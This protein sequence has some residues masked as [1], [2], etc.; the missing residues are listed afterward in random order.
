MPLKPAVREDRQYRPL[1]VVAVGAAVLFAVVALWVVRAPG[2]LLPGDAGLHHWS[3]GHRPDVAAALARAITDTATGVVPYALVVLAGLF[4]GRTRLRRVTAAVGLA[5]CLAVGQALRFGAM[6]LIARPRP[7]A[8]Y[9][10]ADASR[11]SFPSGHATTAAM[12]AGLLIAALYL[13]GSPVPRSSVVL[14]AAWAAT[15]GLTRIY[16]GVHWFTDV[17]GGWLFATAWLA[18][19][20]CAFLRLTGRR[21]AAR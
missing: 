17:V 5:L 20:A 1:G 19:A 14:I 3:V 10:A 12:T 7:D 4:A 16:L 9:W 21:P 8:V 11:W 15:V 6:K 13:R 18:L 2:R